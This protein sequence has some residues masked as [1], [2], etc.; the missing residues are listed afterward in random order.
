[1]RALRLLSIVLALAG[2][3]QERTIPMPRE[4]VDLSPAITPDLNIQRLGSRTLAFLA[5]DGRIRSTPIVPSDPSFTWGMRTIEILSHTGAHLD[6][7][8]RLL[9]GGETPARVDLSDLYGPARVIDL[10]WHNRHTPIQITDLELKPINEGEIVILLIGYE[11]PAA[12]EW[13]RYAP[14]SAQAVEYLTAKK[15]RALATDLPAIVRFDDIESRMNRA[16]PPEEVWA[17]YLPLFQAGIPIIAGLVN[18]DAIVK[19]PNVVF[20]GFPLALPIAD[21]APVRAAAL[22]Y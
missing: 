14:L 3:Q 7:P 21:G 12:G 8:S 19:E 20:V 10:R 5:T 9:R 13:P 22:V 4:I 18:L 2:C 6:A 17:E 15:I 16:Q 11:P 1:M